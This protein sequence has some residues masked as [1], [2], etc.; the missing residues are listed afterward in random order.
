MTHTKAT[1]K[2]AIDALALEMAYAR[3]NTMDIQSTG[4]GK[5]VLAYEY[6]VAHGELEVLVKNYLKPR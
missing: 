4:E 2:Q 5:S 6:G 3:A 1:L